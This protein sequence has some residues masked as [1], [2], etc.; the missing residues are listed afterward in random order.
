MIFLEVASSSLTDIRKIIVGRISLEKQYLG[1]STV[2]LLVNKNLTSIH[3]DAGAI[4][5]LTQWVKDPALLSCGVG[6]RHGSDLELL[7]LW[8]RPAAAALSTPSLE[9]SIGCRHVKRKR[10]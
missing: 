7:W 1:V 9:T 4:P 10:K 3:E 8:H 6:H 5:G 2:A